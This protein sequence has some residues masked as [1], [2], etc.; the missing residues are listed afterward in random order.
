MRNSRI[1][2]L[3]ISILTLSGCIGTQV[4]KPTISVNHG[5][6]DTNRVIDPQRIKQGGKLLI[7]PFK[8]GEEVEA[9]DEL[10]KV[11]LMMV[12]GIAEELKVQDSPFTILTAEDADTADLIIKGHVVKMNQTIGLKKWIPG[13]NGIDLKV[14]GEMIDKKSNK[15]LLV[16]SQQK[17][18]KQP[19]EDFKSLGKNIGYDIGRYIM[20]GVK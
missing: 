20:T 6:A 19:Q 17:T 8:A 15:R 12:K 14:N 5:F 1:Y 16:F 9:N 18:G 3:L 10:N 11:A 13:Q 2:C 4:E 7:I